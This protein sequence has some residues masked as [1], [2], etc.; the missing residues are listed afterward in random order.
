M[1]SRVFKFGTMTGKER[2]LVEIMERRKLHISN[3]RN[4]IGCQLEEK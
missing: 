3:E 2:E 1:T 4:D